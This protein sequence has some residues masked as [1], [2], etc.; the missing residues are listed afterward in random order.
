MVVGLSELPVLLHS[1]NGALG[2]S[3]DFTDGE[4]LLHELLRYSLTPPMI[5]ALFLSLLFAMGKLFRWS[6]AERLLYLLAIL[7]LAVGLGGFFLLPGGT[8]WLA[9]LI[10]ALAV[11]VGLSVPRPAL[12]F[13]IPLVLIWNL[14]SIPVISKD[15]TQDLTPSVG[16]VVGE[17]R[18][19]FE[20][21]R[22]GQQILMVHSKKPTAVVAGRDWEM[23]AALR[24]KW[25]IPQPGVLVHP[26]IPVT[27]HRDIDLANFDRMLAAGTRFLV[28]AE[29]ARWTR[30]KHGYDPVERGA[31]LWTPKMRFYQ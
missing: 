18:D 29:A 6:Y 19:R 31:E 27:F 10:P 15:A 26:D 5:L 11:A 2:G 17:V 13:L 1:G 28:A 20:T 4:S 14:V 3:S 9:I 16:P 12:A 23:L 24:P 30:R 25:E 7:L 8:S 22:R 21:L